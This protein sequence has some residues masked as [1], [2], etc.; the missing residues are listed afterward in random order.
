M[1]LFSDDLFLGAGATYMGTGN[2]ATTSTFNGT[3]DRKSVV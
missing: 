3:I 2:Y 1:P